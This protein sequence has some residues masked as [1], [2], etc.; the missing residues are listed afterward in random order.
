MSSPSSSLNFIYHVF[1]LLSYKYT[2]IYLRSRGRQ[3]NLSEHLL[4]FGLVMPFNLSIFS[5]I[6]QCLTRFVSPSSMSRLLI[7]RHSTTR[8]K[9]WNR[10]HVL[11]PTLHSLRLC[12]SYGWLWLSIVDVIISAVISHFTSDKSANDSIR[13]KKTNLNFNA[14][15]ATTVIHEQAHIETSDFFF[16]PTSQYYCQTPLRTMNLSN[17][18]FK[19][20]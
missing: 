14:S 6:C 19:Q 8:E 17:R 1:P 4:H 9:C 18:H 20:A 11:H 15:L 12:N 2:W 3:N 16:S 7:R 10:K 13:E 5:W